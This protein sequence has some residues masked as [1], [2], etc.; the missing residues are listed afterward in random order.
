MDEV[1]IIRDMMES[2]FT[3]KKE[4]RKCLLVNYSKPNEM[5]YDEKY[6]YYEEM[7]QKLWKIWP[8]NGVKFGYNDMEFE[9]MNKFKRQ[10]QGKRSFYA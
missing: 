10:I 4:L 1:N 5:S 6:E 8:K 3:N 2:Y 7:A 9:R